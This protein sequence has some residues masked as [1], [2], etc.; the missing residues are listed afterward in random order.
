[1]Q[2]N[3]A[4]RSGVRI[5][6][7]AFFVLALALVGGALLD[8]GATLRLL[9]GR[10]ETDGRIVDVQMVHRVRKSGYKYMP[11]FRF[12]M[13]NG[14]SYMVRSNKGANPPAFKVGDA[15]KVCYNRDHPE[16]AVIDSFE[17]LW[18]GDTMV[19]CVGL[20]MF[21]MGALFLRGRSGARQK[22]VVVMGDQPAG[23]GGS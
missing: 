6:A 15:V 22:Y 21:G 4:G 3:S 7:G 18:A 17:Q 23:E 20:L 12:V 13:Q 16:L 8:A 2:T 14:Q 9:H 10:V 19:G 1:M 11:V 5:I